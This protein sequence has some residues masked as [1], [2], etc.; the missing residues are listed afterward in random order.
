M[1]RGLKD[2]ISP[3][4]VPSGAL[5]AQWKEDWKGT[6]ALNLISSS[7][8]S[9]WKEDWKISSVTGKR[10]SE[11]YLRSMKRGLKEANNAFVY[12]CVNLPSSMKRGLKVEI[13]NVLVRLDAQVNSM[14]RGLKD[15]SQP[16]HTY[17]PQYL[18]QWKEDWKFHCF[19]LHKDH[20]K[21]TQ[22]KEDWKNLLLIFSPPNLPISA[23]WKEDWKRFEP[24]CHCEECNHLNEKRIER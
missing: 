20:L 14:K 15:F 7:S 18:T 1:K 12:S 16:L 8:L 19:K 11:R 10:L 17:H 6:T 23:Q 22:W 3:N 21:S 24:L 4:P 5:I 13:R 2:L 9:Q